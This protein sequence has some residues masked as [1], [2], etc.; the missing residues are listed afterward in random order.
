MKNPKNP[1]DSYRYT[2]RVFDIP[3][4]YGDNKIV[5]MV[6]DPWT[7]FSYW[8]IR[9]DVEDGVK[10]VIREKG[11]SPV[12][13]VIKIYKAS[14]NE[15]GQD[16]TAVN[17]VE[18]R[19]WATSWYVHVDEPGQEWLMDIGIVASNGE[20]FCLSRSNKVKTPA[21]YMS[22]T[23]DG[24]WMCPEDL[25]YQMFTASGGGEVGKSSL[26]I[27]EVMEKYLK[28][29]LSSGGVSSGMF[30]SSDLIRKK[31]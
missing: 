14:E 30:S 2:E 29:W 5:L 12:K 28:K 9:K 11:L 1:V 10:A 26:E 24:E 17:E 6:R 22:E 4:Q 23:C 13:S 27:R 20:F 15:N 3:Q 7:I 18:L 21:N 19:G 25:Y 8:E 31:R 16:L